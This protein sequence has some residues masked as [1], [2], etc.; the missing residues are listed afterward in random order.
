MP[1]VSILLVT[2][3]EQG[4]AFANCHRT[5]R[6]GET[7]RTHAKPTH[8]VSSPQSADFAAV[9]VAPGLIARNVPGVAR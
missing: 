4:P 8:R 2:V 7:L 9:C 6:P 3:A 5:R 1:A